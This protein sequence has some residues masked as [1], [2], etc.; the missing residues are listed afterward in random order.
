MQWCSQVLPD[1]V[2]AVHEWGFDLVHVA[3]HPPDPASELVRLDKVH[4][5]RHGFG[6]N[7]P[8][9][10]LPALDGGPGVHEIRFG[11]DDLVPNGFV[12]VVGVDIRARVVVKEAPSPCQ[13]RRRC[14]IPGE[15]LHACQ[16]VH[17]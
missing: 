17:G 13:Q 12:V 5:L 7:A 16:H 15:N 6:R 2:I 11:I 14:K 10:F 4:V 1:N 8:E 3:G 9:D